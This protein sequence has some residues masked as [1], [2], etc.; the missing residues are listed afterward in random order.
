MNSNKFLH[1]NSNEE[2]IYNN[3][4]DFENQ[5]YIEF[6][7]DIQNKIKLFY[8]SELLKEIRFNNSMS[9]IPNEIKN[10]ATNKFILETRN[11]KKRFE[12]F[13]FNYFIRYEE[14]RFDSFTN[15]FQEKNKRFIQYNKNLDIEEKNNL[16]N[17]ISNI[18]HKNN[19]FSSIC[20]ISDTFHDTNNNDI[21]INNFYIP[22]LIKNNNI[23][24]LLNY[25][26]NKFHISEKNYLNISNH[27]NIITKYFN[28]LDNNITFICKYIFIEDNIKDDFLQKNNHLKLITYYQYLNYL[29]NQDNISLNVYHK[30]LK[31]LIR[32]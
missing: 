13:I 18:Y 9:N 24:I 30:I 8:K 6:N 32:F 19:L 31:Y 29:I 4:L 15:F 16:D 14:N 27:H 28:L 25:N 5:E 11:R 3:Y 10:I 17:N 7:N 23:Y 20:I 1:F 21:S 12:N 26:D 2:Y 22:F